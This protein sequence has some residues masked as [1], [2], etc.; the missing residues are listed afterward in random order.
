MQPCLQCQRIIVQHISI[1]IRRL[2]PKLIE[3]K[4]IVCGQC[5]EPKLIM[6]K[7]DESKYPINTNERHKGDIYRPTGSNW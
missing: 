5:K 7:S 3:T 2:M 4:M 6:V 1:D